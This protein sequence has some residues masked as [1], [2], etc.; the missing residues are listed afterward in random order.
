[1]TERVKINVES[2]EAV[3]GLHWF[4]AQEERLF[5][6]EGM[7]VEIFLP[8]VRETRFARDDPRRTDHRL[9]KSTN[10]QF[11]YEQKKVD[12]YR[13]C[14]WGQVRR[15]YDSERRSPI[16]TKRPAVVCQGVYVLPDSP[17]NAPMQLAG[18]SVGV[19]YHQGSHYHTLS[20]LEGFLGRDEM[21][22]VHAGTVRERFEA[23][24]SGE[25]DAA[26]LM[27]PWIA[28]AEKR[29]Y[30]KLV[31]GHYLGVENGPA[32]MDPELLKGMLRAIRKSVTYINRNP[33]KYVKHLLAE[34]PERYA[35]E[36][37]PDDFYLPR[38]RYVDP[39]P[40]TEEEFERQYKWMLTW[41]LIPRDA[42]YGELVCNV[43]V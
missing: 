34:I 8:G 28:L 36:L 11:L 39:E 19:Q 43:T 41:D 18:K 31:E 10:Y 9:V 1:M 7:E 35:K 32:D 5:E 37:T 14:S 6:E 27:E 42:E 29:G 26:T 25:V 33:K 23:L 22:V 16:W 40:Y 38:L 2:A 13:A 4:V 15:A 12:I 21:N 17:V 24:E 20:M 30:K 3:L